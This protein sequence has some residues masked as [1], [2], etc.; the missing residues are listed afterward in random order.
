VDQ[1]GEQQND[2]GWAFFTQRRGEFGRHAREAVPTARHNL[3]EIKWF[4]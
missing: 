4:Q 1:A 3:E 2:G